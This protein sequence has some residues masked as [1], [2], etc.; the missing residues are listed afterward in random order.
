MKHTALLVG[1]RR[2]EVGDLAQEAAGVAEIDGPWR[3]EAGAR[4][5]QV[6]RVLELP[7]VTLLVVGEA[8]LE[9][10]VAAAELV[11]G[12]APRHPAVE[13]FVAVGPLL[14]GMGRILDRFLLPVVTDRETDNRCGGQLPMNLTRLDASDSTSVSRLRDQSPS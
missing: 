12:L 8:G 10:V 4:A 7:E 3:V 14:I 11:A 1:E 9:G 5:V 2:G 13:A 6:A